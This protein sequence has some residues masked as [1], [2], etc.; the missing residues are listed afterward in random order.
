MIT[1]RIESY[2]GEKPEVIA[3]L[4]Y[5]GNKIRFSSDSSRFLVNELTKYGLVLRG[6]HLTL[7]DGKDFMRAL[8]YRYR[9]YPIGVSIKE[10]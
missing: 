1:A 2:S 5:D 8:P 4:Q 10:S 3:T 6:R 7:K 9:G